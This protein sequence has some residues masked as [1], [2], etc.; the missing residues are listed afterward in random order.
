[1]MFID[2]I[3]AENNKGMLINASEI[4]TVQPVHRELLITFKSGR[5]AR[6][7]ADYTK[8]QLKLDAERIPMGDTAE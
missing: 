1:M 7:L 5:S 4:E 6:I 3:N 2:V 8:L